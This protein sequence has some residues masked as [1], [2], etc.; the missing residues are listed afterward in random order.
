MSCPDV[1]IGRFYNVNKSCQV[2]VGNP[3]IDQGLK[4]PVVL[5]HQGYQTLL[6][7]SALVGYCEAENQYKQRVRLSIYHIVTHTQLQ[8]IAEEEEDIG[9]R[10][11]EATVVERSSYN[12]GFTFGDDSI[13]KEVAGFSPF[14]VSLRKNT[15][16]IVSCV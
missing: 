4:A 16:F 2:I 10:K 1:L 15:I 6:E 3:P 9:A 13:S 14:M 8:H 12:F 7:K 5:G 11:K